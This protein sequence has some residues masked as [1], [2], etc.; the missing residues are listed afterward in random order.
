MITKW[1]LF[2]IEEINAILQL[3][4]IWTEALI[5]L[6]VNLWK[7]IGVSHVCGHVHNEFV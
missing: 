2:L 3:F 7:D 5:G 4:Y 1:S 6:P